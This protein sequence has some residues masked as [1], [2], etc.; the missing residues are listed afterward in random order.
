MPGGHR[1]RRLYKGNR[2]RRWSSEESA[3]LIVPLEG[4][5]STTQPEGRGPTSVTGVQCRG[6][7]FDCR[8]ARNENEQFGNCNEPSIARPSRIKR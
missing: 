7:G 6:G 8:M 4:W 3:G 1:Q 2:S 5:D